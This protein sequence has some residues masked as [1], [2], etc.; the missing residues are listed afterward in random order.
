ML[1]VT[2]YV[3]DMI[4]GA[5]KK[6]WLSWW[7]YSSI[8]TFIL[9]IPSNRE[10]IRM[11]HHIKIYIFEVHAANSKR[12]GQLNKESLPQTNN[13]IVLYYTI[14]VKVRKLQTMNYY[15]QSKTNVLKYQFVI[16]RQNHSHTHAW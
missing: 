4:H 1:L 11:M 7:I 15:L 2:Y 13:E 14:L 16:K 10:E 5:F 8:A 9:M 3:S 6:L 12:E